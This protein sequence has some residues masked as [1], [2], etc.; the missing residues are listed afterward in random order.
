MP[1]DFLVHAA[2]AYMIQPLIQIG[3]NIKNGG[4]GTVKAKARL[5]PTLI[6]HANNS[7]ENRI[8]FDAQSSFIHSKMP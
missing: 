6:A 3:Y 2:Q 1:K 4:L 5:Q 7:T 8:R